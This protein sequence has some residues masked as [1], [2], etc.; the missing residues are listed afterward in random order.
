MNVWVKAH[1]H[2]SAVEKYVLEKIDDQI[3]PSLTV[4]QLYVLDCLHR[5]DGQSASDLAKGI[6]YPATAFTPLLDGLEERALI[7]RSPNKT[8]RRQ[9]IISLTPIG[10]SLRG[11]VAEALDAAEEKFGK[12]IK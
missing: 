1:E 9:I 12:A 8:D 3:A 7:Q 6:K 5:K 11:R 2:L 4:K 10:E